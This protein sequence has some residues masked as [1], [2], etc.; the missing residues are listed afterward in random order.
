MKVNTQTIF[1]MKLHKILGHKIYRF[2]NLNIFCI[3][4]HNNNIKKTFN[5]NK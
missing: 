3:T 5:R 2:E 4:C 1:L